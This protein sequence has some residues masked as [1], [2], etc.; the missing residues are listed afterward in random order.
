[1]KI[2]GLIPEVGAVRAQRR[3]KSGRAGAATEICVEEGAELSARGCWGLGKE[4]SRIEDFRQRD[5]MSE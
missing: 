5:D 2:N 4:A 1:M 3:E